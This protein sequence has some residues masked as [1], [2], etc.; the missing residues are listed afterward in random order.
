MEKDILRSVA[1]A[2]HLQPGMF[3]LKM[4]L[5]LF[6][7]WTSEAMRQ[8]APDAELHVCLRLRGGDPQ[9]DAMDRLTQEMAQLQASINLVGCWATDMAQPQ[10]LTEAACARHAWGCTRTAMGEYEVAVQAWE[11]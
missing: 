3:Y 6:N 11:E 2:V 4:G 1:R 7:N 9:R 10:L 5:R 8:V